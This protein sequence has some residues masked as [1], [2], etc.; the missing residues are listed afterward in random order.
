MIWRCWC[1]YLCSSFYILMCGY[2]YIYIY[3]HTHTHTHAHTLID[4]KIDNVYIL[5]ITAETTDFFLFS[6]SF[7]LS[8]MVCIFMNEDELKSSET[9]VIS[10]VNDFFDW[11]DLSTVIPMEEVCELQWGFIEKINLTSL[12]LSLSLYIYIY[13]YIYISYTSILIYIY[14]Y[15]YIYT[16]THK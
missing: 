9:D 15:I 13:I 12:S 1:V 8:N 10:S 3:T 6:M 5:K 11:W 16:H 7:I 4:K 14:I 2:I